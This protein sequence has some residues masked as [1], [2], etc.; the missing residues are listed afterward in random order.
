MSKFYAYI[1]RDNEVPFYVGKGTGNR[2]YLH[3]TDRRGSHFTNR[4]QRLVREGRAPTIEII[5]ALDEDHAKF[6]EVCLIEV[7]GRADLG[8]G[9]LLNLTDGGDGRTTW[10]EEQKRHHSEKMTG[11]KRTEETKRLMSEVQSQIPRQKAKPGEKKRGPAKG[12]KYANRVNGTFSDEHRL[13]LAQSQTGKT[14]S[15]ETRAK[16]AETRRKTEER[17]KMLQT[18]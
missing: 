13:K 11:Q 5:E 15:P 1:Y 17:K 8:K 9:T 14:H 4:V 7:I 3:L 6:L 12:T 2:A 16:I 18:T 10:S